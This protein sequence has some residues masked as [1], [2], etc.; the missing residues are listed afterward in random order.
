LP[1]ISA[2]LGSSA[3]ALLFFVIYF[4]LASVLF[5]KNSD[6]EERASAF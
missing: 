3:G 5:L 4:T 2:E 6:N 1:D